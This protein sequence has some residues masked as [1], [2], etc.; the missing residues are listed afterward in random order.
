MATQ[1]MSL[2]TETGRLNKFSVA[3]LALAVLALLGMWFLGTSG[4]AIFAVGAGHVS[5]SQIT[6]LGGRGRWLA[7]VAL[8]IGYAIAALAFFSSLAA[9]PAMIQSYTA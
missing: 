1:T 9:I 4:L 8:V 2:H 5:L 7:I 6:R 3:A